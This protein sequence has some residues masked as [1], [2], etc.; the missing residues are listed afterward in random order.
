MMTGVGEAQPQLSQKTH[1]ICAAGNGFNEGNKAAA[2]LFELVIYS[3]RGHTISHGILLEAVVE[4]FQYFA[5]HAFVNNA[6][7]LV[8]N[9]TALV[10]EVSFRS[11]KHA[12]I[13]T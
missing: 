10:Y 5:P 4:G 1:S 3:L 12:Q 7:M 8:A 2:F 11:A 9:D 13:N 6:Y